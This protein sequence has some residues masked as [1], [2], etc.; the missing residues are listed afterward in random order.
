MARWLLFAVA[1]IAN[2][3]AIAIAVAPGI[4]THAELPPTT[5]ACPS[6][7]TPEIQSALA[8]AAAIGRTQI[9][10]LVQSNMWFLVAIALV[11]VGIVGALVRMLRSNSTLHPDA[12]ASSGLN[13]PPSA[14]AG[15]RGR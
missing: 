9:Q 12:R 1:V 5:V 10:A 3:A 15:E 7:S 6:C 13:Q 4:V 11:N 14:R 8:R 2:L